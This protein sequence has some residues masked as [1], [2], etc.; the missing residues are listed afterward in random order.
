MWRAGARRR[1]PGTSV[2]TIAQVLA[3]ATTRFTAA[4]IGE[5]ARLV[6]DVLLAHAWGGTRSRLL[7]MFRDEAAIDAKVRFEALVA[8]RVRRE[9]LSYITGRC[10]FY[11]IDVAVGPG[12]LIPRPETELLVEFALD[13]VR[14]R[15]GG[16]RIADVGTGSGAIAVAVARGEAG[17]RVTAIDSSPAA[18]TIARHNVESQGVAD[19]VEVRTGDL[20]DGAGTYDVILANL[21]YVAEAEWAALAPEVRDWEPREALVGGARGTEAIERLLAQAPEHLAVDGVLAAEM[22]ASQ[23]AAV[24]AVARSCFPDA[25]VCVMKDLAGLERVLVVRV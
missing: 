1:R 21:P 22:G 19:R 2:G 25:T 14:R 17:V 7:A 15:G 8:R 3:D 12:V 23:G 6:A 11:G 5:D 10:E 16:L 4:G 9:P 24:T 20:L 13:E 18:V